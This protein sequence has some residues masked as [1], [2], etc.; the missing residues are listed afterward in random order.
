MLSFCTAIFGETNVNTDEHNASENNNKL[1]G[2]A[3]PFLEMKFHGRI[4]DS[5]GIQLYQSPVAAIAELV[6]NGWDADAE[7][8]EVT[9]PE[10]IDE[11]AEITVADN[12]VGMSLKECQDLYLA[13][14]QNRR[15]SSGSSITSGKKRPLLGRKGIGKFAGFGIANVIRVETIS[16]ETG[17]KIVFELRLDELRSQEFVST[18]TKKIDVLEYKKPDDDRARK[19]HGTKVILKELNLARRPS[20]GVFLTS[21]ARR[22]LLRQYSE[23]FKI[24]INSHDLPDDTSV[25]DIEFDFPKDYQDGEMPSGVSIKDEWAKEVLPDGNT[26]Y[27][28]IMFSKAPIGDAEVNGV[29]V[30][31]RG[32]LAQ[33]PF[34][35]DLTGGLGGQH[36]QVYMTGQ[37]KADY[38][39]EFDGAD[40]I[41]VERQRINWD[42]PEC[43]GLL[44]WGQD[45]VKTLLLLWQKKRT[46]EKVAVLKAKMS[47]FGARLNKLPRHERTIISGAIKQLAK[48][49]SV[50]GS[51]FL[52]L[53]NAILTAWEGGRLK[54]LIVDFS[55][56]DDAGPEEILA[57][58][59]ESN[60]L[61]ALN[62]AEAVNTKLSTV[63]GLR[64][65]IKKKELENAIRDFIAI[66]P[67]LISPKWE[68]FA[69]EKGHKNIIEKALKDSKIDKDPDW[70]GRM[71]LVLVSGDTLLVL[72]F[73]R[74]GLTVDDSHLNRFEKYITTLRV[75]FKA[76]TGS[77][78]NQVIGELV[79]DKLDSKPYT[80]ELLERLSNYQM[81]ARDW[82]ML[83]D[84][85]AKQYR[86]FSA[87]LK[88]RAPDDE[89][90]QGI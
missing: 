23:N 14:G 20:E 62:V 6:S 15:V 70:E 75:Y 76:N 50:E 30:F 41:A 71:D 48:V 45:K 5:L 24:K 18:A 65:R 28:R 25:A 74:P 69:I 19:K 88:S 77:E 2:D 73:M 21:M 12:G 35:F 60:V 1:N 54:D 56:L 17:E 47:P 57:L 27:W 42:L 87:V 85:A 36:G 81:T 29:S 46:E 58:L 9:L 66:H 8:V 37:V 59:M 64:E 55:E 67:W 52:D 90:L 39:D 16:S 32:K 61:T 38:L 44:N 33:K 22:F 84:D 49:D 3:L 34:F 82:D 31:C 78:I 10:N 53:S 11:G 63:E 43:E 68:T 72:E 13:V 89:R 80:L 26:I 79:A 83:L 86:E 4:L 51:Q 7:L 40:V